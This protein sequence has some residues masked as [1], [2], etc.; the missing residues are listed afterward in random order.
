MAIMGNEESGEHTDKR[1]KQFYNSSRTYLDRLKAHDE[2]VFASYIRLCKFAIPKS[3]S[4]LECGCGTGFSSYL[5]AKAGFRVIGMDISSLFLS[6]GVEKYG[7]QEGLEFC[8]GDVS[9]MPFCDQSFDAVTSYDL[10]EH[11]ADVKIILAEMARVTKR[12]GSIIIITPNHLNPIR[13]LGRAIKWRRKDVYK[14][15]EA[16]SRLLALYK[17]I[18]SFLLVISKAIGLNKKVYYLE[19]VLSDD[20]DA[21]GRDFDAT[22]LTNWFDIE[23]ILTG[24]GFS[25]EDTLPRDFEDR[26]VHVMRSLKLPKTLQS[27]YL[28]MRVSCVIMG[29]RK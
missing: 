16:R 24:L 21:C 15:W 20:K 23:N 9:K 1:L 12:G 14:P 28:R 10:L 11:V 13:H 19:P 22:W 3:S 6:E 4:I 5:L 7:D 17:F 29:V 26:I 2:Q 27:F 8:V 25:I 18:S